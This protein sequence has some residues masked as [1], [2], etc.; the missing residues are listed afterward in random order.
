[1]NNFGLKPLRSNL[2]PSSSIPRNN[3]DVGTAA[4][5]TVEKTIGDLE[6]G[7]SAFEF[8]HDVGL[9]KSKGEA[10]RLITQGGAYINGVQVGE[11]DEKIGADNIDEAGEI[12]LRKGKKRHIV[13]KVS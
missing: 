3:A 7:V 2:F 6:G 1:V 8:F 4:I 9:C 5:P 13:I 11:F 12:H 10:R